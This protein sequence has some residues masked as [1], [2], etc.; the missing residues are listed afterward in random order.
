[1]P[2]R[3]NRH[4]QASVCYAYL[5][6]NK[7]DSP[8]M[9]SVQAMLEYDRRN[10]DY[11]STE[12]GGGRIHLQSSP[13]LAEARNQVVDAF[14]LHRSQ[15]GSF[16]AQWLFWLDS[17]ATFDPWVLQELMAFADPVKAPIV[18]ALAFGG[19]SPEN[20]FPTIYRTYRTTTGAISLAK[21][22]DYPRNTMCKVGATGSHC[23]LIHRSVF[24]LLRQQFAT[25]PNGAPNPSPW[26]ADGHVDAQG[27]SMGEDISFCL[28]AG[29]CNIPIYVH[30]GIKTG[31]VKTCIL[32]E[33]MWD[34]RVAV[35]GL[36]ENPPEPEAEAEET[37]ALFAEGLRPRE[38]VLP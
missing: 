34:R 29:A 35:D 30:T 14:V 22:F 18:G 36:P 37:A 20:L 26:Y 13:R 1:M 10:Q 24:A 16:D 27:H 19:S 15:G 3:P 28:K 2:R 38:L 23:I 6:T 25:M 12:R 7:V 4:K 5:C 9:D 31:H 33:R 17:D 21:V 32:D 11:L 8:F